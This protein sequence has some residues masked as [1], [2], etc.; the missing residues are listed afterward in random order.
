[1]CPS[2]AAFFFLEFYPLFPDAKK[3][4]RISEIQAKKI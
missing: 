1:L 2:V 4:H 3:S